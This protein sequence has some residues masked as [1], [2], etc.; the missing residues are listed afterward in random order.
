MIIEV[1]IG[2]IIGGIPLYFLK[3]W[4]EGLGP[5]DRK[6]MK[7]KLLVVFFVKPFFKLIHWFQELIDWILETLDRIRN[8]YMDLG[9][10]KSGAHYL[11]SQMISY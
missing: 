10:S 4:W 7:A 3:R 2:V 1:A 8:K 11:V 9:Y 6:E 5:Q